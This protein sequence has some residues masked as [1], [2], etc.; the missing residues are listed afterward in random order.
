MF[1][2]FGMRVTSKVIIGGV[3]AVSAFC[4]FS[5][6]D[7]SMRAANVD[8]GDKDVLFLLNED[9]GKDLYWVDSFV[10][11]SDAQNPRIIRALKKVEKDFNEEYDKYL[12]RK[13]SSDKKDK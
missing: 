9:S 2:I 1:Y 10:D 3:V 5:S 12:S 13:S 4:N 8:G 6:A 11:D 7:Y